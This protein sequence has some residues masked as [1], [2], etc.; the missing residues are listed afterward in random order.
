VNPSRVYRR[1]SG[2]ME[3]TIAL[4]ERKNLENKQVKNLII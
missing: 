1:L 4:K 2:L 3:Q